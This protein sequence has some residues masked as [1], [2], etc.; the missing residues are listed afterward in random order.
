MALSPPPRKRF[1]VNHFASARQRGRGES[2]PVLF[3]L[4]HVWG[5]LGPTT[6]SGR[7]RRQQLQGGGLHRAD[8][9]PSLL[10]WPLEAAFSLL[11]LRR[12]LLGLLAHVGGHLLALPLAAQVG[13]K[14]SGGGRGQSRGS[15]G[16]LSCGTLAAGCAR[17]P[18]GMPLPRACSNHRWCL[19]ALQLQPVR[20]LVRR[21]TAAAQRAVFGARA[22]LRRAA[23]ARTHAL[24]NRALTFFLATLSAR[25]SLPIVSSSTMRFS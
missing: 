11:L 22:S 13:A 8:G 6:G 12:L 1:F 4:S 14:L 16:R 23:D 25:L 17:T 7:S 19:R 5:L 21:T 24:H 3:S 2:F 18:S 10:R 20:A 9:E 15:V